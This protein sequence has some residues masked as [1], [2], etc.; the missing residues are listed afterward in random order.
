MDNLSGYSNPRY[1]GYYDI[2]VGEVVVSLVVSFCAIG[3]ICLANFSLYTHAAISGQYNSISLD[4]IPSEFLPL[5]GCTISLCGNVD[6]RSNSWVSQVAL[7]PNGVMTFH[8]N[9]VAMNGLFNFTMLYEIKGY[10]LVE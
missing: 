8:P 10:S 3:R 5:E 9:A 2:S 4:N 7:H 6:P 1:T